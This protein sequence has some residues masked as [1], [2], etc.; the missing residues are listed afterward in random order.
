MVN[1]ANHLIIILTATCLW[2]EIFFLK[3]RFCVP[4]KM[5]QNVSAAVFTIR[6]YW[7]ALLCFF[8]VLCSNLSAHQLNYWPIAEQN[9]LK[10][11][12]LHNWFVNKCLPIVIFMTRR[13]P[14]SPSD[15]CWAHQTNFSQNPSSYSLYPFQIY[16]DSVCHELT[17]RGKL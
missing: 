17:L 5:W 1:N 3:N 4:M 12:R 10:S 8:S 16:F 2:M 9:T 15:P 6:S 7:Q 14:F 11:C 13:R